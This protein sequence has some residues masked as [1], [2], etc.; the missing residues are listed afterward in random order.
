MAG[1]E[2][3]PKSDGDI[4]YAADVSVLQKF[5]E[6]TFHLTAQSMYENFYANEYS[7]TD[8]NQSFFTSFHNTSNIHLGSSD[9]AWIGSRFFPK[10]SGNLLIDEFDDGSIDN[11]YWKTEI[12]SSQGLGSWWESGTEIRGETHEDGGDN[13]ISSTTELYFSGNSTFD[14]RGSKF[15]FKGYYFAAGSQPGATYYPEISFSML[16][17]NNTE[18]KLGSVRQNNACLSGQFIIEPWSVSQGVMNK[19]NV[20]HISGAGSTF[21]SSGVDVSDLD[22]SQKWKFKIRVYACDVGYTSDPSH[23]DNVNWTDWF[24]I[25]PFQKTEVWSS[26]LSVDNGSPAVFIPT[27]NAENETFGTIT[28]KFDGVSGTNLVTGSKNKFTHIPEASRGNKPTFVVEVNP[29]SPG[30]VAPCLKD[31]G[32]VWVED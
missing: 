10:T 24:K 25:Y 7:N 14:L 15:I 1:S 2:V 28:L 5:I 18:V 3:F 17:E 27:Y 11:N 23:T 6:N 31:I 4:F 26:G 19:Y 21:I 9:Y 20:I 32:V 30:S 13:D 29:N 12:S 8:Y 16:D 22:P